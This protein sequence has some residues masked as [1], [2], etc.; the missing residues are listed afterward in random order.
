MV[1]LL[2]GLL[3]VL[4][5]VITITRFKIDT[6]MTDLLAKHLPYHELDR[7]YHRD[8]PAVHE[9][10][11]VVVRAAQAKTLQQSTH[12]LKLWLNRHPALYHDLYQ[13]GGGPSF[14]KTGCFTS[15]L[16]GSENCWIGSTVQNP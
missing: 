13:P 6:N 15:L 14:G 9:T 5:V 4:S 8:F 11:V 2:A 12:A 16:S 3:T 10:I 1:L 7:E